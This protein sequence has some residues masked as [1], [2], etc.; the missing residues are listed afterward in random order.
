MKLLEKLLAEGRKSDVLLK[1]TAAALAAE[2]VK[3]E[4]DVYKN[5]KK[6][7][8]DFAKEFPTF[9]KYFADFVEDEGFNDITSS[10]GEDLHRF[11]YKAAK[12]YSKI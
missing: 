6:D 1:Q 7:N 4:M 11:I 9:T 3:A 8:K 10:Y 12:Q 5:M 2:V